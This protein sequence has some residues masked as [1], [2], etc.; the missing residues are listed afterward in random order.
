MLKID[1][2]TV[3]LTETYPLNSIKAIYSH[4]QIENIWSVSCVFFLSLKIGALF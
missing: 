3:N 2:V 4:P 1:P